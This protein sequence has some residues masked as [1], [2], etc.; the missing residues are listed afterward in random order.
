VSG[1]LPLADGESTR[2]ACARAL[3]RTG[4]EEKTGEVLA[5]A[6]VMERVGWCTDL[7]HG[8][9]TALL[10]RALEHR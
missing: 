6:A 3:I 10:G 5:T 2:T 9:T 8:M 7:V 1:K 4:V